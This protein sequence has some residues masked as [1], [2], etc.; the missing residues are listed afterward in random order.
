MQTP[1]LTR[2]AQRGLE[3]TRFHTTAMC[4]PTRASLLTGRNHHRVANGIVANLSTGYPGYTNLL[5]DSAA[6]VARILREYGYNT[7]MIGKHH[8]A[9]EPHVSAQGPFDL[10]PTGLGFEYFFGFMGAETN[11]FTPALYRGITPVPTLED[12]VLDKALADDAIGWIHNQQAVDPEKPFFL[13]IATGS[14]HAPLQAPA[15]W[16]ARY[17]GA[18]DAGWDEAHAATVARQKAMGILKQDASVNP[19]P[20]GIPAWQSMT[21]QQKRITARTMEAYAGMLSY[22]D[23]QIGRVLSEL[24]RMG[25]LDNTLVIHIIGDN[26]PAAEAG[27]L[28]STNPMAG[29][30]NAFEESEAD[31]AA[32]I[33]TIGG[34]DAVA[35][36]AGG[37]V[38]ATAAPY[39]FYKQYASHLGGVANPMVISWPGGIAEPGRRTQFAH[40][41]DIMPT[42]LEVAGIEAPRAVDGVDQLPIDGQSLVYSFDDPDASERHSTQ[43]F[44][45][46]GNRA[47]YHDGWW[48]GTKPQRDLGLPEGPL[49]GQPERYAWELYDLSS[50]PAQ[51]RNLAE[52]NPAK[53]TEMRALF[54]NEAT[55]NN[56]FP[57]DDRLTMERFLA[58]SSA[59]PTRDRYT[60][61][62]AGVS[63]PHVRAAPL[64]NRGF[65]IVAGLEI[66]GSGGDGTLIALGSKFGGW[67]F[68]LDEGVPVATMAASQFAR[69][70]FEVRGAEAVAPGDRSVEFRFE[71]DGGINAGGTM[72]ILADGREIG[73]GRIDRT[74]SK[75]PEM[76]DTL[77]IGN[78]ADT[79]VVEGTGPFDGKILRIDILPGAPAKAT[80]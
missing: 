72:I 24:E 66:T 30:A 44:E 26:G 27:I 19:R 35:Q 18:F 64:L 57:L 28:G 17:S 11:Q 63:V 5:P 7:A 46:M 62:G 13:Y 37:W 70:V 60:Y 23:E 51:A 6:T 4:S 74:V 41:T 80:R 71:Y 45:M 59:W 15:E 77:D 68:R 43:Y 47:I 39:P 73:R 31:L 16:I 20:P 56:V 50:D 65:R 58:A 8:N 67:S 69:D 48:A 54:E 1:H 49:V 2:L 25:E 9:P 34:P 3:Y 36:Y 29:F 40:V 79:P 33:D 21:E 22:Q 75:L 61:W 52:A 55:A 76:T 42:I 78:D 53:L 38:W 10:W 32:A 14:A 12:G